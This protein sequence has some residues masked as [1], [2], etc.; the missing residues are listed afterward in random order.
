MGLNTD[1]YQYLFGQLEARTGLRILLLT[2]ALLMI[3]MTHLHAAEIIIDNATLGRQDSP[4]GRTFT[5]K[6]CTS[7][8]TNRYG[9]SSFYSCGPGIESYRWTPTIASAGSYDVYVWWA[10]NLNRSTSVPITVVHTGGAARQSFNQRVAGG[11]WVLHGRYPLGVGKNAYVEVSDVGGQAGADA[12]RI[13]TAGAP[14]PTAATK[15]LIEYG[16]DMRTIETLKDVQTVLD[17]SVFDGIAMRLSG[18]DYIFNVTAHPDVDFANDR[19]LLGPIK[20][21]KLKDSFLVMHSGSADNWDWFNDVHWASAEK[22]VRNITSIAKFANMRGVIFDAEPYSNNPWDYVAQFQA[23]T[24]TFEQYQAQVRKRGQQYMNAVQQTY[25]GAKIFTLYLVSQFLDVIADKPDA[26]TLQQRL[27]EQGSGLWFSFVN[28]MLDAAPTG[29]QIVDGNELAYYYLRAQDF[30]TGRAA[31]K[32]NGLALIASSNHAKYQTQVKVGNAVYVDG[33]M[34]LWK[35]PRF[36]GYFFANDDER[37]KMLE[38]NT[39]H[40]FRTSDEFVWIYS[41]NTNW[42]DK[43][44]PS[45]ITNA[46]KSGKTK[47]L[48]GQ[49]LGLNLESAVV[50]AEIACN[51]R[52]EVGGDLARPD[53]SPIPTVK[54][55]VNG[56][57]NDTNCAS[58]NA[59]RRYSCAFPNGWSGKIEVTAAGRTVTP[60]G[61]TYNNV[62]SSMW[63]EHYQIRP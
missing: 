39:Y 47:A 27:K 26:A 36:C 61:R 32:T 37:S 3:A 20:S 22:N 18:R 5:G 24:K 1:T 56:Q 46:I 45:I 58:W 57:L 31:I 41:E 63:S 28:G 16:W 40:S 19:V 62:T 7:I 50:K 49:A 51:K 33:V 6:W 55:Y 52:I 9:P 15:K 29:V 54:F 8:A 2:I 17:Q 14:P 4:G 35:T 42:W 13:V 23:K 34:N 25:P 48:T 21:P 10:A 43:P 44:I 12:V 30:D 53:G 11:R 60:T 38:H 59:T